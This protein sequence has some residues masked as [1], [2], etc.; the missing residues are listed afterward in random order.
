MTYWAREHEHN[1]RRIGDML[2][3]LEYAYED[4]IPTLMTDLREDDEDGTAAARASLDA[5]RRHAGAAIN[6][7]ENA[8]RALPAPQ[9]SPTIHPTASDVM[10]RDA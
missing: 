5:A 10:E 8:K 1:L 2:R 4:I 6:A 3:E 7:L 9:F